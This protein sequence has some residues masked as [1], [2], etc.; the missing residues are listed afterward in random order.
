MKK[1][2]VGVMLLVTVVLAARRFGPRLAERGMEKC[3]EMIQ[4]A[5]AT[6]RGDARIDRAEE[7]TLRCA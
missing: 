5:A 2:T 4:R 3:H 7:G 1:T 6:D